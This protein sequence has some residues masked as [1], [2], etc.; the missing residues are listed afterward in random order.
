MQMIKKRRRLT[1]PRIGSELESKKSASQRFFLKF[2]K[3]GWL[4]LTYPFRDLDKA[5]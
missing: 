3:N 1:F 5:R 4:K 2:I